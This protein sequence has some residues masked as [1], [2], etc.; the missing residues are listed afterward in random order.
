MEERIG[1]RGER[2]ADGLQ[3]NPHQ[4]VDYDVDGIRLVLDVSLRGMMIQVIMRPGKQ[5]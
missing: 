5:G 2:L 1:E 4:I 3:D